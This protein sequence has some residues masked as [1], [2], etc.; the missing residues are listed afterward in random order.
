MTT[1]TERRENHHDKKCDNTDIHTQQ[2][3]LGNYYQDGTS[4]IWER[5]SM[6]NLANSTLWR[7]T[8][9]FLREIRNKRR[10][11]PVTT[12]IQPRTRDA[13]TTVTLRK[14]LKIRKKRNCHPLLARVSL[15]TWE[16]QM[17]VLHAALIP[18]SPSASHSHHDAGTA[19]APVSPICQCRVQRRG[20]AVPVFL[21][22]TMSGSGF[23]LALLT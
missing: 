12:S 23:S 21:L 20:W 8:E 17:P 22:F 1:L 4:L 7:V 10:M 15:L 19:A 6:T 3:S 11:S 9:N 2:Q 13:P 16:L 14:G 18:Q 5:E